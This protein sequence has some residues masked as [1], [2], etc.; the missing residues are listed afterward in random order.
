MTSTAQW[1]KAKAGETPFSSPSAVVIEGAA[2]AAT[3][4]TARAAGP[5][6][7]SPTSAET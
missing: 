1:R 5:R 6:G 3:V 7:F 4:A 2:T